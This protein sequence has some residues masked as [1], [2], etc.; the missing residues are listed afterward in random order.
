MWVTIIRR[1]SGFIG[2]QK[3]AA[4]PLRGQR[5]SGRW[6]NSTKGPLLYYFFGG[7]GDLW[8][9]VGEKVTVAFDIVL[10]NGAK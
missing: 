1:I 6:Q 10:E 7:G 4:Q 3:I 5:L 9:C 2:E 8:Y